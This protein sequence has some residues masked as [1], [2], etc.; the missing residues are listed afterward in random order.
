[1]RN[2]MLFTLKKIIGTVVIMSFSA[3]LTASA[4]AQA[5][6]VCEKSLR[7][8]TKVHTFPSTLTGKCGSGWSMIEVNTIGLQ[9]PAGPIGPA[10][11]QGVQGKSGFVRT[12]QVNLPANPI[13][14]TLLTDNTFHFFGSPIIVSVDQ[15]ERVIGAITWTL[16]CNLSDTGGAVD[17]LYGL[18]A[19]PYNSNL[20]LASINTTERYIFNGLQSLT[21]MM[22]DGELDWFP[23]GQWEIGFCYNGVHW[24]SDVYQ[25]YG[26]LGFI[27][28]VRDEE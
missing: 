17:F 10:G 2:F 14:G 20:P 18:C 19:R 22:G 15:G 16:Y 26:Q 9:G 27:A 7:D 1:M 24:A 11:P 13:V 25:D 8:G 5:I 4:S 23:Y 28:V 12:Y 21:A 6:K 3:F